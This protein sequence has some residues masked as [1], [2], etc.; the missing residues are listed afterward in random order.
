MALILFL[1]NRKMPQT[2]RVLFEECMKGACDIHVSVMTLA[3]VGYLGEKGRI[4]VS[5]AEVQSFLMQE[6]YFHLNNLDDNTIGVA[7]E[8]DDIPELHD[9]LIAGTSRSLSATIITNDPDMTRSKWVKSIW[10]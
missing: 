6:S 8:I 5:L 1:E 4:D 10:N 2:V 3:E 7:F 9:R